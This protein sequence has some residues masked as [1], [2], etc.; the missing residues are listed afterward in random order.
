MPGAREIIKP[1][2]A[3]RAEPGQLTTYYLI[4]CEPLNF[5]CSFAS[6]SLPRDTNVVSKLLNSKQT[7]DN[8][9]QAKLLLGLAPVP[10]PVLPNPNGLYSAGTDKTHPVLAEH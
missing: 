8:S 4:E 2:S 9:D 10:S 1:V 6:S 5:C 3:T 7:A